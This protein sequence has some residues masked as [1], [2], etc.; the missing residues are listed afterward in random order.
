M[1]IKPNI[2]HSKKAQQIIFGKLSANKL[3]VEQ[4]NDVI[5][6]LQNN[7]NIYKSEK[8]YSEGSITLIFSYVSFDKKIWID[9]ILIE[10]FDLD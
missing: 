4:V 3:L 2:I 10:N 5:M 7:P 6:S 8:K 1:D 9:N